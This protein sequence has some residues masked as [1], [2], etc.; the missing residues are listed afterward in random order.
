M[1]A[2]IVARLTE[3]LEMPASKKVGLLD[4]LQRIRENYLPDNSEG[5]FTVEIKVVA[6][7]KDPA[8]KYM[9]SR[10]IYDELIKTSARSAKKK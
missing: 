9:P 2:E 7:P 6:K 10:E 5:D 4:E 3:S 8:Q 1:N